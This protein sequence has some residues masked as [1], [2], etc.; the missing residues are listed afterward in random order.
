[1]NIT[2]HRLLKYRKLRPDVRITPLGP[3]LQELRAIHG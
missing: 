3:T 1:V 2:D